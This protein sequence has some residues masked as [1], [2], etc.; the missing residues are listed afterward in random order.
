MN[1]KIYLPGLN[2]I[3]AIAAL[4]VAFSHINNRFD[5]YNLPKSELLDLANFGVTIFFTLSGFLI[6]YLLLVELQKTATID[7]RKFYM[8][9]IL[10][11]WPLYFVYLLIVLIINGIDSLQW[12]ILFYIFMLPNLRNSFAAITNVTVGSHNLTYMVGHY[13][14]LGVEEQFYSFWPWIIKRVK[15]LLQFL[16]FFPI[17]YVVIKLLLRLTHAPLGIVTFFNYTRFGCLAI[18]ALGAYLYFNKSS[19]LKYWFTKKTVEICAWILLLIVAINK[20]HITSLIDH[21]L[22]AMG[23]LVLIINQINNPKRLI[24]LEYKLFDYL[25]K[26]SFGLYVY[27]PLIIYLMAFVI[28]PMGIKNDLVKKA[29]IY[30]LVVGAIIIVSHI[31][32]HYFEKRFLKIKYKYTTIKSAASQEE[33][34]S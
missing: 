10:R 31:S 7:V 9:R 11:I 17:V 18:G 3:R 4:S 32:Y 12:P 6:T 25:G 8:R 30:I 28:N 13:W 16:I 21:E 15:N 2:G 24:S 14:S 1:D 5:Y 23:T 22:I 26:I 20:F 33:A 34:N 19:K 27:N 29:V